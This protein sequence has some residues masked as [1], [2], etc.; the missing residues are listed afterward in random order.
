MSDSRSEGSPV[1][2]EDATLVVTPAM[3]LARRAALGDVAC[4]REL[5]DA[6]APALTRAVRA[7]LGTGHP[8]IEDVCQ[9]AVIAFVQA[10]PSFRG[11]CEPQSFALRIGIRIA[12]AARK[13][14]RARNV[15]HADVPELERFASDG[16]SPEASILAE[17][18]KLLLR[19]LLEELPEE[20][21]EALALRIMLGWSLE[22]VAAATSAPVNTVR[23]RVRI[24]KDALRRRIEAHPDWALLLGVTR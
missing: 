15:H 13:R 2:E 6:I 20:Q 14:L 17:R 24:A 5:L 19:S 3:E 10:L 7:V 8:E 11:E 4:T 18:R 9:Q 21:A 16:L 1:D 12:I 23:S 22:E